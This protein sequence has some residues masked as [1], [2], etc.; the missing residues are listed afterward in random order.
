MVHMSALR[1]EVHEF[2]CC[3]PSLTLYLTTD[4]KS[5]EPTAMKT[6]NYA[7]YKLFSRALF[8]A[9]GSR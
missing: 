9:I 6:M 3:T 4:P 5:T 7:P 2:I 8:T 1:Q